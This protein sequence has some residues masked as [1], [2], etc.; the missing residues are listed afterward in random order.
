MATAIAA[1]NAVVRAAAAAVGAQP[2]TGDGVVVG[3]V[4]S[5]GVTEASNAATVAQTAL[6]TFNNGPL[7]AALTT[8][9]GLAAL[10]AAIAVGVS[11]LNVTLLTAAAETALLITNA[12]KVAID[13]AAG[14]ATVEV[15]VY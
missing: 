5:I 4:D 2:V 3:A 12:Q 9:S 7:A 14:A 11:D 1:N 15:A 10:K 8:Q 13:A 6:T